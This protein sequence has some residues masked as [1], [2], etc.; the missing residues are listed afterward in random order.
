MTAYWI[1]SA[2]IEQRQ[3]EDLKSLPEDGEGFLWLD[4]PQCD[5]LA[6]RKLSEEFNFHAFAIQACRDRTHLPKVH[7]YA[8]HLFVILHAPEPG[9]SGHIHLLE[10]DQFIG[11]RYL[12]TVH[13]P[14]GE[15]VVGDC[16]LRET[17]AVLERI[18][19]GRYRPNFPAEL[20]YTIVTAMVRTVS[21]SCRR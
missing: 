14:L 4:I 20:S 9:A 12:V 13:G 17:R 2:K 15:G 16:A 6:L 5:E 10:L 19:A 21:N 1:S 18:E 11:R 8:D 3:V 7:A